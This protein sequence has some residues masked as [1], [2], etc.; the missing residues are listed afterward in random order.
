M[1]TIS[2]L[3]IIKGYDN[4]NNLLN[5]SN[6]L[7]SIVHI[8]NVTEK[9]YWIFGYGVDLKSIFTSVIFFCQKQLLNNWLKNI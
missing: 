2:L 9:K 1:I 6:D 8:H 3:I 4:I 5:R 7:N